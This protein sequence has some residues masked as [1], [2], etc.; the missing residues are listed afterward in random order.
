MTAGAAAIE[1]EGSR[2]EPLERP[3]KDLERFFDSAI[4][5][6]GREGSPLVSTLKEAARR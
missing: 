1:Q 6:P 2:L 3:V 4:P 5:E